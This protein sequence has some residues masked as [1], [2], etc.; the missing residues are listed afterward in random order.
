MAIEE[1]QKADEKMMHLAED[2]KAQISFYFYL[3]FLIQL[4]VST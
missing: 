3:E 4:H 1:Q 2:H